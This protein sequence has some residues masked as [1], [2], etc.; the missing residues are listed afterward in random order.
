MPIAVCR[1]GMNTFERQ[2]LTWP[3]KTHG[4]IATP[5]SFPTATSG[6]LHL[7]QITSNE[8]FGWKLSGWKGAGGHRLRFLHRDW[9]ETIANNYSLCLCHLQRWSKEVNVGIYVAMGRHLL[10][11]Y[12]N[13]YSSHL[14]EWT[15]IYAQNTNL[16]RS[17]KIW[18]FHLDILLW[19][20]N[21]WFWHD[22]RMV[23]P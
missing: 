19:G 17:V 18:V 7:G 4:A 12:K 1:K 14:W 2:K 13:A 22:K 8:K 6:Q 16:Q 9:M 10:P 15:F 11:V 20:H 5:T 21:S 23:V 3:D